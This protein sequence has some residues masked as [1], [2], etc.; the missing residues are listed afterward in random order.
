VITTITQLSIISPRRRCSIFSL[1]WLSRP[2]DRAARRDRGRGGM[3]LAM[4]GTAAPSRDRRLSS[5]FAIAVIAGTLVGVPLSRVPLTAVRSG[6]RSP[7]PF[8][9]L[10][11]GLVGSA[12]ILDLARRG[13]AHRVFARSPSWSR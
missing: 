3:A 10:A 13:A 12:E 1:R 4:F 7:T 9:G 6:P 2:R 11:A 5:G 8:G